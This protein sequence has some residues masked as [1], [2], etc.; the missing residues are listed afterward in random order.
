MKQN[1]LLQIILEENKFKNIFPIISTINN[2]GYMFYN[3]NY[4]YN[5][6]SFIYGNSIKYT[7]DNIISLISKS[8]MEFH[9]NLINS[10]LKINSK[11]RFD[12]MKLYEETRKLNEYINL[13]DR[14]NI[15]NKE[16]IYK[17]YK[18]TASRKN[19]IH[20]DLGL[21]NLINNGKEII[22]IDFGEARM[23]DYYFDIASIICSIIGFEKDISIIKYKLN[24]FLKN[25]FIKEK[26]D[27]EKLLRNIELWYIRGILTVLKNNSIDYNKKEIIA[28]KSK[29]RIDIFKSILLT[30][31]IYE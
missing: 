30:G 5:L 3:N 18:D 9:N 2:N 6:Q 10:N 23:G 12:L 29:D 7:D 13:I 22:I 8:I 16:Y 24:I 26:V 21:Q 25:Y 19:I 31:G 15:L 20:G 1:I 4:Y 28:K 27:M 17:L 11:D 14:E